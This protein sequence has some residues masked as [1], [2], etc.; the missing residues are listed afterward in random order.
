[1]E[2]HPNLT[3]GRIVPW[4]ERK[5]SGKET[6]SNPKGDSNQVG[7]KNYLLTIKCFHCHEMGHYAT[8]CS[9]RKADKKPSRG[10]G[11]TLLHNSSW[12]SPSLHAW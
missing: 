4:M 2:P 3:M 1:M 11:E 9:H 5:R 8:K 10:V 6:S 7:K 12:I